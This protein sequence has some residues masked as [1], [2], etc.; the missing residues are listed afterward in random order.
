MPTLMQKIRLVIRGWNRWLQRHSGREAGEMI[1]VP[2]FDA[3][4][5]IGA[6]RLANARE[7]P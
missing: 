4:A 3:F 5:E 7:S 6:R 1:G 2:L